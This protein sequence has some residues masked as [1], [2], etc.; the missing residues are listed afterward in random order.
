M[1]H[2]DL[3]IEYIKKRTI[4]QNGINVRNDY[5]IELDH[6]YVLHRFIIFEKTKNS[7]KQ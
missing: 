2:S 7:P 3:I 1:K 6:M 4:D 5:S